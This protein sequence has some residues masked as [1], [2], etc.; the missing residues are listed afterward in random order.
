M[1]REKTKEKIFPT[2]F[3]DQEKKNRN[4]TWLWDTKKT[5]E[6]NIKEKI[7]KPE[8]DNPRGIDISQRA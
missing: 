6:I 3:F 8:L 1:H 5:H 2:S 7:E 4:Q